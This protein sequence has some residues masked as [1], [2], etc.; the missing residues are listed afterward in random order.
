[1]PL[2]LLSTGKAR[3]F[4]LKWSFCVHQRAD[5]MVSSTFAIQHS[6]PRKNFLSNM[7]LENPLATFLFKVAIRINVRQSSLHIII[8]VNVNGMITE[9]LHSLF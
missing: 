7:A 5:E 1:M 2:L 9:T 8:V 6:K 4:C 3:K